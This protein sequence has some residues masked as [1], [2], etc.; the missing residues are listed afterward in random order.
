[1]VRFSK[2]DTKEE[3]KQKCR[4]NEFVRLSRLSMSAWIWNKIL[5]PEEQSKYLQRIK[6]LNA[7]EM[8]HKCSY[9]GLIEW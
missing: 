1:M 7:Y 9:S 2:R 4:H 3:F 5:C 8:E 6:E